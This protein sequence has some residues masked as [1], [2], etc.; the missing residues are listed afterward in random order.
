[1]PN[2]IIEQQPDGRWH[3]M[4]L[5]DQELCWSGSHWGAR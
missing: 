1:M 3:I 2:Y 5:S 4:N